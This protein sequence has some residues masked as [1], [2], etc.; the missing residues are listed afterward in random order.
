MAHHFVI[1]SGNDALPVPP[2]KRKSD[3]ARPELVILKD[4][5]LYMGCCSMQM[6]NEFLWIA[7]KELI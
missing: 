2:I 3:S 5:N 4:A 7:N 1:E 6:F